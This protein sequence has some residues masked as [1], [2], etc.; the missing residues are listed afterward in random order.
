MLLKFSKE[1]TTYIGVDLN[2][3]YIYPGINFFTDTEAKLLNSCQFFKD[4][5][6]TGFFE[7][8]KTPDGSLNSL[9]ENELIA[10]FED[11]H[12]TSV[13]RK[14]IECDQ[15]SKVIIF[16]NERIKEIIGDKKNDLEIK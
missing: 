14:I 5:L 3:I 1:F 7:I 11:I 10:L 9:P 12:V 6:K 13:L 4:R 16:A 15:R 8:V 2:N